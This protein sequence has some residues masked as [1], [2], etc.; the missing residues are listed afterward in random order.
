[1][2]ATWLLVLL[3]ATSTVGDERLRARLDPET[4]SQ[5]LRPR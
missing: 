1:M 4:A 2:N 5:V 3:A